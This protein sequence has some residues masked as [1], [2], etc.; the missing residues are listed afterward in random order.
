MARIKHIFPRDELAHVWLR[1]SQDEGR[2]AGRG[3]M[4]FD[5]DTIYSY[6]SHFPI[7]MIFKAPNG[8]EVIL[9]TTRTYSNTTARHIAAVKSACNASHRRT[10]YCS[11]PDV[12]RLPS[13]HERNLSVF[14]SEMDESIAKH[15]KARKPELYTVDILHQATLA[16]E[17]CE[18][19]CLPVPIW[20]Q[21]PGMNFVA[22]DKLFRGEPLRALLKIHAEEKVTA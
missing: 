16:R 12:C 7:A 2:S 20:A 18:V 8:E 17:Y 10:I 1:Q 19:M 14:R 13:D 4:Y 3:Q 22:T 5:G 21:L 9:F 15:A 6:G 11:R